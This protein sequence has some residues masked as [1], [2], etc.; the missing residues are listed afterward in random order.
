MKQQF[1]VLFCSIFI[2]F[3]AT[4]CKKNGID[5]TQ[6][7]EWTKSSNGIPYFT[8]IPKVLLVDDS[9]L[10]YAD[11]VIYVGTSPNPTVAGSGGVYRSKDGGS[12]WANIS[13]F[14]MTNNLVHSLGRDEEKH[15]YATV[16]ERGVYRMDE[17]SGLPTWAM[18]KNSFAPRPNS[19]GDWAMCVR[20]KIFI[21]VM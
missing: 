1:L 12:N 17:S 9:P 4:T 18:W 19:I 14:P 5:D 11:P 6:L 10:G 13:Y 7:N 8:S 2:L 15:I 20:K 21:V 16:D 3:I